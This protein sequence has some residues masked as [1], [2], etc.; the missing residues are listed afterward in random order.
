MVL[1]L[2]ILAAR[3]APAAMVALPAVK[4]TE[5]SAAL[6]AVPE[7]PELEAPLQYLRLTA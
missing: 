3:V 6:V 4:L 1:Q 5:E 7:R 2:E